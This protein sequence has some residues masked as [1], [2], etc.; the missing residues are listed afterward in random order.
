MTTVLVGDVGGTHARFGIVAVSGTSAWTISHRTDLEADR[1]S[2]F[3]AAL[4]AYLEARGSEA[5]PKLAAIAVAGP[6]SGGAVRFTNR[7]WETSEAELRALGFHGAILI[8][9]F[10]AL[11]WSLPVMKANDWVTIGPTLAGLSDAPITVLGAGT[12]FGASCLARFRGRALPMATE[13]GHMG[14][15]PESDAEVDVLRILAARFGHVSIERVLSGPGLENLKSALDALGNHRDEATA[16]PDIVARAKAGD[17]RC[18]AAVDMF[19]GIYGSVAGDFALAH[20][21]R[22]GV[23][24]GGGIAH[25]LDLEHSSFRARFENKGRLS[26]FVK[27][28]PTRLIVNENAAFLGAARAAI[29]FGPAKV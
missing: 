7:N 20:G 10:A 27:S 17:R 9:D 6:V 4:Q 12:G 13:G 3:Q 5:I 24:I 29:E 18:K 28:I 8:N 15:A 16:A 1:Y 26:Y 14:F 25:N 19:C 21:A 11:A 2:T 22:G 23:Y